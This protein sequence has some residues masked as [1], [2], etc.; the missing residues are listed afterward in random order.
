MLVSRAGSVKRRTFLGLLSGAAAS[1]PLAARAQRPT[2]PVIG[3]LN[4]SSPQAWAPF[5]AAFVQ[6]LKQ[7]GYV[8]RQNV[9]IEYRWA[10]RQRDPV[11]G[12]VAELLRHP[13]TVL[14]TSGGDHVVGAAK[15]AT[16]T[17]PILSTFA[18]DPIANGLVASLNRPGGNITGVSVFSSVLAAKRLE[19]L[20][21][22]VPNV[23]TVAY[24]V[25]PANP[26]AISEANEIMTAAQT[27]AQRVIVVKAATERDCEAVFAELAKQGVGALAIQSDPFYNTIIG[28]LVALAKR[29]AIPVI[30]GRREFIAAGGLMSYGSSSTEAYRQ[31]GLYTARV[32][33]GTKPS[34]LP[35]LLPSQFELVVNLTTAKALGIDLPASFMVRV[36]DTID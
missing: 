21:E 26:N 19:L 31:L 13:V 25:N 5:T 30:Y 22:L 12:L 32:L 17:T 9:V 11:P 33:R 15:A 1:W 28:Q 27:L 35:I 8:D 2:M 14:V 34:D 16:T 7:A 18:T 3:F 20:R 4:S 10:Q 6:G 23:A 24:L 29:Y 36:D